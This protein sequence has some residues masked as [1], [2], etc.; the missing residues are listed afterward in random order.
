M[1]DQ[2]LETFPITISQFGRVLVT[3][4]QG[5]PVR[6]HVMN[7]LKEHRIVEIDLDNVEAYTPS[8]MDEVLGKCLNAI[9]SDRF[10]S[11]IKLKASSPSFLAIAPQG[12]SSV[13]PNPAIKDC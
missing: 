6:A 5:E 12:A 7:L 1:T 9:G 13:P 3:R 10:R 4:E 2:N 8:F 11:S